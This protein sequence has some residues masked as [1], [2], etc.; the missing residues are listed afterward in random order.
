LVTRH[1]LSNGLSTVWLNPSLESDPSVTATDLPPNS[2]NV[3]AIALRQNGGIGGFFVDD[4]LLGTSF[5]DV[6]ANFPPVI[7]TQ[8]TNQTVFEGANAS[9]IV[10]AGGTPPL[11]YQWQFNGT[12]LNAATNSRL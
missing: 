12:N 8:P 2:I 4:L 3:G 9:F 11:S 10:V 6:V 7:T 5:A 1:V